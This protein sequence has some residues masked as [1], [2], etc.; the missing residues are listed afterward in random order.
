MCR[1]GANT[2]SFKLALPGCSDSLG[3]ARSL[4]H[5]Q[6]SAAR[7]PPSA[8]EGAQHGT[9]GDDRDAWIH[10]CDFARRALTVVV[11]LVTV[12]YPQ[13]GAADRN[14]H[15]RD[16]AEQRALRDPVPGVLASTAVSSRFLALVSCSDR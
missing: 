4:P 5:A 3:R 1:I 11:G 9:T 8:D 16:G 12:L 10:V 15:P 14:Y 6:G 2:P 13:R 7:W